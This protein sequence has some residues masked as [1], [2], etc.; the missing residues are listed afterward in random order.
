MYS[1]Y[2]HYCR[3]MC[4]CAL[5]FWRDTKQKTSKYSAKGYHRRSFRC[6]NFKSLFTFDLGKQDFDSSI[7]RVDTT[8]HFSPCC[9]IGS[10]CFIILLMFPPAHHAF[11]SQKNHLWITD[12]C[13]TF[14]MPFFFYEN[15]EL[16]PLS[17]D[18]VFEAF[19]K[20]TTVFGTSKAHQKSPSRWWLP[21]KDRV[22]RSLHPRRLT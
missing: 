17:L 12:H 10:S 19:F 9:L 22:L 8:F 14:N 5:Q 7:V 13:S 15:L 20:F 6:D 3:K 2:Q 16:P 11:I 4:A 21:F 18:D 1:D